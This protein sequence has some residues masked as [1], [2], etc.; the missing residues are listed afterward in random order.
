[1]STC[2]P[3]GN[4]GNQV[5]TELGLFRHGETLGGA[6]FRGSLDDPLT[7][8][9]WRQMDATLAETG[10][11]EAVL[12]S[13]LR[14]CREF[15]ATQAQAWDVPLFIDERLREVHFGEWEGRT[16]DELAAASPLALRRFHDDPFRHPP[17]GGE[18]LEAFQ[19]RVL[20]ALADALDDE[21]AGRRVLM[22]T[23]GGVIRTMLL[24]ARQWPRTR[25]LEIGVAPASLHRLRGHRTHCEEIESTP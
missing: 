23:H 20:A 8:E 9:G 12:T 16:Y 19:A 17:P 11:W 7:A 21:P 14:R 6:R 15:A 5:I 22:V 4:Y 24:Q 3:Y 2:P 13:P 10:P 25:L 1:M 18:P